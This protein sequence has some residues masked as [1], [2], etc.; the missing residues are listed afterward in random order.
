M[1]PADDET[2]MVE[3]AWW[4][5]MPPAMAGAVQPAP[6]GES[7]AGEATAGEAMDGQAAAHQSASADGTCRCAFVTDRLA[8][9]HQEGATAAT[10]AGQQHRGS[11][12]CWDTMAG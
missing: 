12:D 3:S 1:P 2:A 6:A 8:A 10:G 11:E 4:P 5:L 7:M 9:G